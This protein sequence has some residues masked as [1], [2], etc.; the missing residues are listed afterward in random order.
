MSEDIERIPLKVWPL[1]FITHQKVISI[2][3]LERKISLLCWHWSI[4]TSA[5]KLAKF[6]HLITLQHLGSQ[7]GQTS[8]IALKWSVCKRPEW[9]M[10]DYFTFYRIYMNSRINWFDSHACYW[11]WNMCLS[12]L[13]SW[14]LRSHP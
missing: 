5:A 11:W 9:W 13:C 8:L 7:S 3:T 4:M 10:R 12:V 14:F 2:A 6:L 1:Q